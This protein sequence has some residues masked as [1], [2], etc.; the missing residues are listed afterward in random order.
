MQQTNTVTIYQN[1]TGTV[2]ISEAKLLL[3]SYKKI[4]ISMA[5]TFHLKYLMTA[6]E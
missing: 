3:F 4:S 1:T 2:R 6:N 5:F